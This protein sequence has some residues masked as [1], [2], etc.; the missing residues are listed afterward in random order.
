MHRITTMRSVCKA[1][2]SLAAAFPSIISAALIPNAATPVFYLVGDNPFGDTFK[3]R[4]I[5]FLASDRIVS[6]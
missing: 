1:A 2:F 5:D 3:V 4:N 6:S